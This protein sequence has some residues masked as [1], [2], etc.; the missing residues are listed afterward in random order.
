MEVIRYVPHLEWRLRVRRI[1]WELP[2]RIYR[3]ADAHYYD[4]ATGHGIAVKRVRYRGKW[5]ELVVVYDA[6]ARDVELVTIHP[7]RPE[8]KQTRLESGRWKPR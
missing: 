4:T 3:Q 1:S 2:E 8:Q 5:R 6:T 7:L